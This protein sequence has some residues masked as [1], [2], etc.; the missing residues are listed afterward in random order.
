MKDRLRAIAESQ[1]V[2][3]SALLTRLLENALLQ[4]VGVAGEAVVEPVEPVARGARLYVRLRPEDHLLLR[5]RAN[6]RGM[7]AATLQSR[8]VDY[9][10]ETFLE[11]IGQVTAP[12]T[13]HLLGYWV[14]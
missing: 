14:A 3:E 8:G 12:K 9:M 7:A 6:G 4:A 10:M 13:G 11:R 5:E 2:T 1:Q